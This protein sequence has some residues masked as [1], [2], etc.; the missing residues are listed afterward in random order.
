MS[1][2]SGETPLDQVE[3]DLICSCSLPLSRT[4]CVSQ[5]TPAE[6]KNRLEAIQK[7]SGPNYDGLAPAYAVLVLLV[8]L[9][10]PRLLTCPSLC[11][12]KT[13]AW[14]GWQI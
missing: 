1:S 14:S 13:A 9:P 6:F 4:L 10:T 11:L 3:P 2:L 8:D 7:T 12:S 5:M